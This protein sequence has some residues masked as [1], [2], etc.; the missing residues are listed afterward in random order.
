[1]P[2]VLNMEG[3]DKMK[4][5]TMALKYDGDFQILMNSVYDTIDRMK[6]KVVDAY[7]TEI[8]FHFELAEQFEWSL[9]HWS[10][11]FYVDAISLKGKA[12]MMI[13]ASSMLRT[14]TYR[15]NNEVKME[16]F[17]NLVLLYVVS[18]TSRN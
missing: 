8:T 17:I 18:K 9:K 12:E 6:L 7:T 16:K 3:T 1:M 5:V 11:R 2:T 15:H 14:I 4:N 10:V 13:E